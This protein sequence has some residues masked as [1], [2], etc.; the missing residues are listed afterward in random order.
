M[1]RLVAISFVLMI[2]CLAQAHEFW[3]QPKKFRYKAG[4]E[5]KIDLMVGEGFEGEYWDLKRHKVEKLELH[6]V[7][8]VKDLTK[9]VKPTEGNNLIYKADLGGTY[10]FTL[11]S[12]DAYIEQ[13]GKAFNAYLEEDGLDYILDQR[14]KS[15]SLDKT[16]TEY[17]TRFAK[18]LVQNGDRTDRTFNKVVGLKYEIVPQ[19]N[20][21]DLKVGDYLTCKVLF[22]GKPA[23]HTLV[24]VWN[25]VRDNSF[26]QNI[27]TEND[28]T[29]QFPISAAGPWMVS[30]V[31][32]IAS[33]KEGA[34]YHSLWASLVFGI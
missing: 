2:T 33:E 8:G 15:N 6:R 21:Y 9:D 7:S 4:E 28:G 10:L 26:M 12:N 25:R 30:S 22:E 13:E 17:Y 23:P 24:K 31:R 27:Y 3:L 5:I 29:I 16:S 11:I 19:Q 14:K 32:M 20:P 1:K 34:E 18:L